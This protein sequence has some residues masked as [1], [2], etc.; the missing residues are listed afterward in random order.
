MAGSRLEKLGTIFSRYISPS[1][2]SDDHFLGI[3]LNCN[4]FRVSVL[5]RSGVLSRYDKP[6]WYDVYQVF[7]PKT[8]PSYAVR[9]PYL[10]IREILYPEDSIRA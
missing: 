5:L 6:I 4:I 3:I 8:E 2:S 7:P 10:E 9:R 1:I